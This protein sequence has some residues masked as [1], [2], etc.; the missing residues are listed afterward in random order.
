MR[1]AVKTLHFPAAG[2]DCSGS[3][4]VGTVP[5]E[6]RV[7]ATPLAYNMRGTDV[8]GRRY[9]GGSRPAFTSA[10][11]T[12]SG[13]PELFDVPTTFYRGRK[14]YA[15]GKLWHASRTGDFAD[16]N[17]GGDGEDPTRPAMGKVGFASLDDAETIT[18]IFSVGNDALY[19]S[20]KS[21]LWVC[22]EDVTTGVFLRV[23]DYAGAVS[24]DA[25]SFDG[26]RFYFVAANG[27]YAYAPGEGAVRISSSVPVEL[28]GMT[29][30]L[31]QYDPK[32]NALHVFTDKGDWYFEIGQKAWWPQMFYG[33]HRPVLGCTISGAVQFYCKDGKWRQF[34]ESRGA[35]DSGRTFLSEVVIG[36]IR[37][38]AREDMDGMFDSFTAAIAKDSGAVAIEIFA[39]KTAEDAYGKMLE[40]RS[41]WHDTILGGF[42]HTQRPRIRG[43]WVCVRLSSLSAWA[44]ESMT[45]VTKSLGGLR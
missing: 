25:W 21:A 29:E 37:C 6:N 14:I 10:G 22:R 12:Q 8:F 23:V 24:K 39:G 9:R 18:A 36:P 32:Y 20:T 5:S 1:T 15:E 11:V 2:L 30:A 42:N 34:D 27:I 4:S 28:G 38:S 26:Q 35:D 43:A 40:G 31:L 7:Y 33:E 19:I 44:F 3:F 17:V 16:F 45:A 13:K 41:S